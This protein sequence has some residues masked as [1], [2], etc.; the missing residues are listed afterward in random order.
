MTAFQG[1]GEFAMETAGQF[2][3]APQHAPVAPVVG[4]ASSPHKSGKL[5]PLVK[6]GERAAIKRL[7]DTNPELVAEVDVERNTPLHV[8]VEAPRNEVATI[9][10]LLEAGADINAKNVLGAAPLHYVAL[11]KDNHRVIANVLLENGANVHEPA[12]SGKT[13]LHFACEKGIVDLVEVLLLFGADSNARANEGS[14][15]LFIVLSTP[16]GRDVVKRDLLSLL[17]RFQA[18]PT[19]RNAQ[20]Y[21][22]LHVACSNGYKSCARALLENPAVDVRALT[23]SGETALHLAVSHGHTTIMQDLLANC[24]DLLDI[25]DGN[26]NTALHRCATEGQLECAQ[27]L[28]CL[29]A[30]ARKKNANNKTPLDLAKVKG[31]DLTSTHNAELVQALKDAKK[32]G[33]C[34]QQ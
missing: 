26:G 25:P 17:I 22:Q 30:D 23:R 15:P 5:F 3:E 19:L 8:A 32:S 11:R 21:T 7:L 6:K 27:E 4:V 13:A 34:I 29:G 31:T 2:V 33:K 18:D 24:P 14:T 28:L 16:G 9:Q 12:N 20:E 1:N 10:C